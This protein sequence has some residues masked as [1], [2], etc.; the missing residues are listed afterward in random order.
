MTRDALFLGI[1]GGGSGC[2]A[3]VADAAGRILGEGKG[4][5][6]NVVSD[7]DTAFASVLAA[8]WGA[9]AAAG[10]GD[11][12][13]R[14]VAVLGLAGANVAEAAVAFRARL[15]FAS[16]RVENDVTVAVKGALGV[17]DGIV[18]AI[19]TGAIYG[20]QR[21]GRVR[22]AGGW[23]LILGDHGSGARMG[24]DLY[25]AALLAHDGF[26]AQTPLLA[27]ILREMRS[28]DAIVA[29]ARRAG[30]ADFA[31]AAPRVLAAAGD[32]AADRILADADAAIAR[33][34]DHLEA[35]GAIPIIFSGGLGATFA[36][37]L[38]HRYPTLVRPAKGSALDGALAMARDLVQDPAA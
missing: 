26:I 27:G 35:D 21:G 28:P 15:P 9:M 30:P 5:P 31:R 13:G 29:F 38:G 37:R 1:D 6:A 16:A 11:D 23:G 25:E 19:G 4:G 8:A 36:A 2:R 32:P 18:A 17:E 20:T 33:A 22:L 12:L 10:E 34:L 7:P 14:L 24:R 3:A